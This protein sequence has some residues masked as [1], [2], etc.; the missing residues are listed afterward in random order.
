MAETHIISH[1]AFAQEVCRFPSC[2]PT[3]FAHFSNYDDAVLLL[4]QQN[5]FLW[6]ENK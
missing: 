1:N 3:H 4:L 5:D 6:Y 2:K